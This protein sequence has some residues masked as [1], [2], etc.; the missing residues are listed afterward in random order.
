MRRLWTAFLVLLTLSMNANGASLAGS[1]S[2]FS[3]GD[4]FEIWNQR[5][6]LLGID[7]PEFGQECKRASGAV[8]ACG[9]ESLKF[10][11][12]Y[13]A[14]TE[15]KCEGDAKDDHGRLLATCFVNG[16]NLNE[17]LVRKGWAVA[18]I[19]YDDRYLNQ[20]KQ[21]K[22]EKLGLWQGEFQRPASYRNKAWNSA[23]EQRKEDCV[24]KGNINRKGIRIYHTPWGSRHYSRTKINTSYGERWFCSEAEAVKAGWRAPYR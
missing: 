6:R 8:Y 15:V 24:I 13:V 17:T 5:I 4:S 1:I 2:H 3:D 18:F 10:L 16:K 12:R 20:E 14:N 22:T 21:A 7:A 23:A 9:D 11:K 19:R